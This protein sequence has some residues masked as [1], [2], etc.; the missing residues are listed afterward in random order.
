MLTNEAVQNWFMALDR[1]LYALFVGSL[2][3]IV[4]A[5]L[6]LMLALLGPVITTGVIIGGLAAVYVLTSISAA[7]YSL[8]FVLILLPFGTLPFRLGFTPTLLDTIIGVFLLVYLFQWMTG[9]R[10]S[11]QLTPIHGLIFVYVLWLLLAFVLGLRWAVP[12]SNILRQFAETLLSIGLVFV[13]VDFLRDPQMLRRLVFVVI[14]SVGIQAVL[15]LG[16]YVL[17][18]DIAARLLLVLSRIGYPDG[19]I[20]RYIESNPDLA[21]RAIGTWVDPNTLGGALAIAATMIA[22]QVFAQKPVLRYRWLT[23]LVLVLVAAGLFL[24][25]SRTSMAAFGIGLFLIAIARYRRFIPLMVVAG[26]LVLLLPQT[27]GYVERFFDAFTAGD[28][29]TQMRIGEYT[30]SLRLISQYPIFGVGFTGTPEI[31]LYT[32][33]ASMYL[34][35]GNQIGLVG[36]AIYVVTMIGV[37]VYGFHAWKYAQHDS[38]LDSIHLGYHCA[39]VAALINGIG[40]LYYFRIDFQGSITLFWLVVALALASSRLALQKSTVDKNVS[41]M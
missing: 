15:T 35:M 31:G 21:E 8:I 7:L 11:I 36:V 24:T 9:R 12:T 37:L 3:G 38:E 33:V 32:D 30:D 41:V 28:L 16:L 25:Y 13:L 18:N 10:R 22:P 26:M 40:D 17:S 23:L 4:G 39:V 19:G 34:I 29:A 5:G 1:R 14:L 27:Q 2:I 20:I 6:G